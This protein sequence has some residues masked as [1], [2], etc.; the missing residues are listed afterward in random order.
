[1]IGLDPNIENQ[2]ETK[3]LNVIL[4][5]PC[6]AVTCTTVSRLSQMTLKCQVMPQMYNEIPHSCNE[7]IVVKEKNKIP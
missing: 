4:D 5:L 2:L 6:M 7:K 3:F 1:M